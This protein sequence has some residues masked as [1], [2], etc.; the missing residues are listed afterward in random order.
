MSGKGGPVDRVS[1]G[2]KDRPDSMPQLLNELTAAAPAQNCQRMVVLGSAKV[3]KTAIVRRFLTNRD[4]DPD[5]DLEP[6]KTAISEQLFR[7]QVHADDRGLSSQG[8]P[9]PRRVVSTGH[10]GHVRQQPIPGHE[11]PVSTHR[12]FCQS[13]SACLN[14]ATTR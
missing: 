13:A 10:T 8:L 7:R 9:H 5:P 2:L 6:N 4:L 3:G 1:S 14:K 12:S 11:A